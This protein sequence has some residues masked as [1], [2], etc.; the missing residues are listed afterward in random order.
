MYGAVRYLIILVYQRRAEV[1]ETGTCAATIGPN[2]D[3]SLFILGLAPRDDK[4]R[5]SC[6]GAA[7]HRICRS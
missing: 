6:G 1:P 5:L 2:Q 4:T 7:A 3:P